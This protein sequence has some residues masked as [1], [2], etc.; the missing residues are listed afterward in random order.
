[1]MC[2]LAAV[3]LEQAPTISEATMAS[4][5]ALSKKYE[6][7]LAQRTAKFV[8]MRAYMQ[9]PRIG[10]LLDG[11]SFRGPDIQMGFVE[12]SS[13]EY[14]EA[15]PTQD[16]V[17]SASLMCDSYTVPF[18]TGVADSMALYDRGYKR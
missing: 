4:C 8:V 9:P 11:D 5:Y 14:R 18:P 17:D 15:T 12:G 3:M 7:P 13:F 16:L 10:F 2:L 1:M 6:L